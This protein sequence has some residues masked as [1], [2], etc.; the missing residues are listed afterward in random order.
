MIL[1]CF[2]ASS[3]SSSL[4]QSCYLVLMTLAIGIASAKVIG[5]ETVYEPSRY[6]P[7]NAGDYGEGFP[8]EQTRKWP[9]VRPDPSPM[10]S[11]NDRSR[12][13]TI[14]ALVEN[15]TYQI[16]Q[17]TNFDDTIGPW[18]DHGIIFES[19]YDSLDK[20]MDPDTGRF[21]SSKPP[22]FP[23]LI[24][25]EYWLL[26][27]LFNWSI[28]KDRWWVMCTI[29]LTVNVLPFALMLILLSR[30]LEDHGV[31]DYGRLLVMATACG[32]TFLMT[33]IQSLNNHVPAAC[34]VMFAIYPLLSKRGQ[35]ATDSP[36]KLF[37]SGFF[38]GMAA[39]LEMPA[40][41]LGAALFV[42]L[43]IARPG[44]TLLFFLPGMLIPA[45]GFFLTNYLALGQFLPAYT[46]F[47]GPW[48]NYPG[49]YWARLGTPLAKGIDFADETKD[50]YAFH[51]LFG[52]HGWFSLT[53]VWLLALGGLIGLAWKSGPEVG[54]LLGRNPG[55]PL[56]T[57]PLF[58]AMTLTLSIVVMGF[59]ILRTNNYGGFTSG[60]R[61]Y[62]WLIPLWLIATLPAADRLSYSRLGRG[63][64]AVLLGVSVF[65]VFYP[66][67][68]PW[69]P[70][71][72]L[73]LSEL[74]GWVKY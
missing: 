57:M 1:R 73:Q 20:V 56:W 53:P 35:P 23:T 72:I 54:R 59:Y 18:D 24:A 69:R 16:G 4:R 61:W 64:G 7:P 26:K 65:S 46:E 34:F 48:Y 44:R 3:D 17:R 70:P 58:A 30:L 2:M 19:G 11:S 55:K 37:L 14:R 42:P 68:N 67:W 38:V 5:V 15:Q 41:A 52:H 63:V 39:T 50:V 27:K 60:P 62:F 22:L 6:T 9:M 43:L 31:T 71:W 33:F 10:F 66:L 13:A 40:L 47:G 36:S 32:G 74:M 25:G 12:W 51:L 28:D 45:V 49:S 29:L 8:N 21:Y